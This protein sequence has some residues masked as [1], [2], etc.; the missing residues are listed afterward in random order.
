M[1]SNEA[2]KKQ[3]LTNLD[4]FDTFTS[5]TEGA[6]SSA[7]TRGIIQGTKV[8]FTLQGTW[9]TSDGRKIQ[10]ELV[11]VDVGRCIQ[12]WSP[13]NQPL[14]LITLGPGERFPDIPKMNDDTPRA[15]WRTDFNG[16]PC[17]PWQGTHAVFFVD[18]VTM[19]KFTWP[20]PI[21]TIGSSRAVRDLVEQIQLMR[22]FRGARVYP[23]VGLGHTFM[24]TRF[25]GRERPHLVIKRWIAFGSDGGMLPAPSAPPPSA[26]EN[27][28]AAARSTGTEFLEVK[29]PSRQEELGDSIDY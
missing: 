4:G 28:P 16:N 27:P 19:E 12:K 8:A 3:E 13:D 23:I 20:S 5:E 10:E 18:P 9:E 21:T 24:P 26:A 29:P 1:T 15:E 17:G 22:R 6:D 2:T 11:A 25:G 7:K 14:D